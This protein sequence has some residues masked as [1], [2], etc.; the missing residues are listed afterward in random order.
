MEYP[1]VFI[2]GQIENEENRA[3]VA[4]TLCAWSCIIA[5]AKPPKNYNKAMKAIGDRLGVY[6]TVGN[7]EK[8]G[9]EKG[10]LY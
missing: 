7:I 9:V 4:Y 2:T 10:W 3:L 8:Y 6:P 5:G 1:E